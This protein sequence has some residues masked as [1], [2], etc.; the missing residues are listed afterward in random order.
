MSKHQFKREFGFVIPGYTGQ[1][2]LARGADKATFVIASG[3]LHPSELCAA[4]T[5]SK[6]GFAEHV[7]GD[8]WK[9]TELGQ[10]VANWLRKEIQA[11]T[12]DPAEEAALL[13]N[14]C[15]RYIFRLER[16]D[17]ADDGTFTLYTT[18]DGMGRMMSGVKA[19][20]AREIMRLRGWLE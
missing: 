19:D 17:R 10:R 4:R 1:S 8:V 18:K 20:L 5:L 7:G 9:L 15:I 2:L 3:Y 16:V 14:E 6:R 12:N 13:R 11:M